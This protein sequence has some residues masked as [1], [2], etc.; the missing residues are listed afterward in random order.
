ML[1]VSAK[2]PESFPGFLLA[3]QLSVV[4]GKRVF[5]ASLKDQVCLNELSID[6]LT[7]DKAYKFINM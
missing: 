3:P 6:R 2:V 1:S 4:E 5:P 7:G